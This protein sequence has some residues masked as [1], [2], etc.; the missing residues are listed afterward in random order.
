MCCVVSCPR[1]SFRI[2]VHMHMRAL[3]YFCKICTHCMALLMCTCMQ[4]DV[5]RLGSPRKAFADFMEST[6][7]H[8][9]EPTHS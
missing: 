1:E 7:G 8:I 6:C 3:Y 4:T 5:T 2:K 9:H